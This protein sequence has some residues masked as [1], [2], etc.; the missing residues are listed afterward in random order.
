[1]DDRPGTRNI[2]QASHVGLPSEV[3]VS[4]SRNEDPTMPG[5]EEPLHDAPPE[6]ARSAGHEDRIDA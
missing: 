1:M 5:R 3:E 2:Q 4:A 6:E